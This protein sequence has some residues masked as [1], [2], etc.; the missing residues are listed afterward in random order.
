[1]NKSSDFFNQENND[2][3][4]NKINDNI[5]FKKKI[6]LFDNKN[7]KQVFE[8]FELHKGNIKNFIEKPNYDSFSLLYRNPF[9]QIEEIDESNYI[10][11]IIYIYDIINEK[12]FFEEF[13]FFKTD[14]YNLKTFKRIANS[15]K[16]I[17]G[18][19]INKN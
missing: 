16:K 17:Y 8:I 13:A 12:E 1:M 10:K 9:F 4:F 5:D 7:K 18:E 6:F 2:D 15:I 3:F 19:F 14:R 11:F